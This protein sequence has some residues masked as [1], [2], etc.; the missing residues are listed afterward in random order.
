MRV[1]V[2]KPKSARKLTK[3]ARRVAHRPVH[4]A[5][6][7]KISKEISKISKTCRQQARARR[8]NQQNQQKKSTVNPDTYSYRHV[9]YSHARNTCENPCNIQVLD[10][11]TVKP[12]TYSYRQ[13]KYSHARNTFKNPCDTIDAYAVARHPMNVRFQCDLQLL[14]SPKVDAGKGVGPNYASAQGLVSNAV[15]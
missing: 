12:H 10:E 2:F 11:P 9:K 6:I 13:A 5:E 3:S 8:R 4:V 14:D 15:L 7:S 1:L